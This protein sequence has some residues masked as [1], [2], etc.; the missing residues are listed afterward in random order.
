MR[1]FVKMRDFPDK[2]APSRRL[3]A[4]TIELLPIFKPRRTVYDH[5]QDEIT[6]T[7][8]RAH[9]ALKNPQVWC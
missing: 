7:Q 5:V 8:G 6:H 4:P 2:V 9:R 1:R 3:D